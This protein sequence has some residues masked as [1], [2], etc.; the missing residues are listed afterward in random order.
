VLRHEGRERNHGRSCVS[1]GRISRGGGIRVRA[2]QTVVLLTFLT[3]LLGSLGAA[4]T[5]RPVIA[6]PLDRPPPVV[7]APLPQWHAACTG[8]FLAQIL[9]STTNGSSPLTVTFSLNVSGGCGTFR[10]EWQFGDGADGHG[11]NVSHTYYGTG[12]YEVLADATDS[13][14]DEASANSS[15]VVTGGGGPLTVHVDASPTIGP[16]PLSTTLWA[17]VS[18]DNLTDDLWVGWAFGDGGHGIGSP[19]R[20]LYSDP[21]NFTAVAEIR[22]HGGVSGSGQT[23]IAVQPAGTASPA[24]LTVRASPR[25]GT[26]PLNATVLATS[27]DVVAGAT[28]E[29]CFGDGSPCQFPSRTGSGESTVSS[30]HTFVNS[31]SFTI[32][33]TLLA[34]NQTVL[35]G[36]STTVLVEPPS[37]LH[38]VASGAPIAGSAP[39]VVSFSATVSGGNA[40]YSLQWEFGDGAVGSAA[41]GASVR[42]TYERAG[43]FTPH[44]EVTDGAGHHWS[45]SIAPVSVA[46]PLLS[47]WFT[48]IVGFPALDLLVVVLAGVLASVG[49][50]GGTF[51]KARKGRSIRR[52]GEELLREMEQ[53]K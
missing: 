10:A 17:N 38:V 7:V 23:T 34:P 26:A 36:A 53:D 25:E 47:G 45:G 19:L 35:V 3:V 24:N 14:D 8:P 31:G 51:W 9:A 11:S 18:G 41:Q 32:V 16:A 2:N 42:H 4:A 43:T 5:F 27:N 21:G 40:P 48:T 1:K 33:G 30:T 29:I 52:E 13:N 12:T 49:I 46:A 50:L 20:H 28:L 15:I 22:G 37:P 44:L 39:L 6:P